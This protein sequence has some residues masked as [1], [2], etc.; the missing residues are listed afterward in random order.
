MKRFIPD[1]ISQNGSGTR[2]KDNVYSMLLTLASQHCFDEEGRLLSRSGE[3]IADSNVAKLVGYACR[4]E[5]LLPGIQE[6]VS[7]LEQAGIRDVPN[8]TLFLTPRVTARAEAPGPPQLVTGTVPQ[9]PTAVPSIGIQVPAPLAAPPGAEMIPL[10]EREPSAAVKR[11]SSMKLPQP[12]KKV[13]K[14]ATWQLRQRK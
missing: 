8:E 4:Q 6:F 3:P 14:T 2:Q 7:V 1:E 13:Q 9:V 10:P 5:K 11:K 12:K